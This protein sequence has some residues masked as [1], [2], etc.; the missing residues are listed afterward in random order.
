MPK[1]YPCGYPNQVQSSCRLEREAGR[2][3][4]FLW[5]TR[6]KTIRMMGRLMPCGGGVYLNF[7]HAREGDHFR[8]YVGYRL[9]HSPR[10][11]LR[12]CGFRGVS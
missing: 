8:L 3:V 9:V 1:P 12:E 4:E 6:E 2:N 10:G 5:L 11:R 7:I